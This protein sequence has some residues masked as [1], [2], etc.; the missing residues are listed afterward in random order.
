M[1]GK[2]LCPRCRGVINANENIILSAKS[3]KNEVGLVL[4]HEEVGNYSVIISSSLN[5]ELGDVV[6]FFCPICHADLNTEKG[7]HFAGFIR[8]EDSGLESR[9]VISRKYGEKFTFKIEGNEI[10]SYGDSARKYMDPEWFLK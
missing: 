2:Y 9:I 4:L 3:Q 8:V 7:E 6:D 5:V 1:E 10:K